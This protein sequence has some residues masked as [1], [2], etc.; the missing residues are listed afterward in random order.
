MNIIFW[1]FLGILGG[2]G[3]LLLRFSVVFII[4]PTHLRIQRKTRNWQKEIEKNEA[5]I[6]RLRQEMQSVG[7]T[8]KQLDRLHF[9]LE[10]L[11]KRNAKLK[12]KIP[13]PYE[14]TQEYVEILRTARDCDLAFPHDPYI[15]WEQRLE[16]ARKLIEPKQPKALEP[17]Q[18]LTYNG[19]SSHE[20]EFE[21]ELRASIARARERERW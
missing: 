7:I 17:K 10:W 13:V 20:R 6:K 14:D 21:R 9:D 2:L 3:G 8:R 4:T 1:I 16:Y 12:A 11:V 5:E 15:P 18:P 19:R